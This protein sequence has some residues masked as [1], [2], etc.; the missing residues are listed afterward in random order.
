M[1]DSGWFTQIVFAAISVSADLHMATKFV[2]KTEV[3]IVASLREATGSKGDCACVPSPS[4]CRIL[5]C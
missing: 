2:P 1:I 4:G 3:S 5:V